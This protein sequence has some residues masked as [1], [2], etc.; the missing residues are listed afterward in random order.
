M[1][2]DVVELVDV[3]EAHPGQR[4]GSKIGQEDVGPVQQRLDRRIVD[5]QPLGERGP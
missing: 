2:D 1:R 5:P 3:V 4:V